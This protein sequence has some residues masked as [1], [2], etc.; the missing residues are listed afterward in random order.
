MVS[1]GRFPRSC[2]SAGNSP[3]RASRDS[4]PRSL[5]I[6]VRSWSHMCEEHVASG[7]MVYGLMWVK[8][9][10]EAGIFR[11]VMCPDRLLMAELSLH[12]EFRQI[13]QELWFRRQFAEASVARQRTSLFADRGPILVAHVR[14]AR[15]L[16]RHGLWPD[17][18]EG[19]ARSGHFPRR[20]V[21]RSAVDGR[22]LAAW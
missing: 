20:H 3:K 1:S 5:P 10:R 18:G 11:D 4:E 12:G 22:A 6:A 8:A 13:P 2:G 7:D 17:V 15:G 19:C 21:S 9:V 14:R 16:R